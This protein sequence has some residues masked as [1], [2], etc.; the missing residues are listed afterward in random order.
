MPAPSAL[1]DGGP[2]GQGFPEPLFDGEF[3]AGL[4]PWS[5]SATC[6]GPADRRHDAGAIHF[7]GWN[8]TP[9]PGRVRIAY[10]LEP[11]DYRGG[12]AVQLV[13]A[14]RTGVT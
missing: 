4:A 12:D 13:R 1:R 10:R 8:G 11:D 3:D 9:P 5:A 7:G 2:W 6:A 14:P